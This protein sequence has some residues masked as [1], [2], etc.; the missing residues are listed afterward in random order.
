MHG[1]QCRDVHEE[2]ATYEEYKA[3]PKPWETSGAW[4]TPRGPGDYT[5]RGGQGSGKGDWN[6]KGGKNGK[7]DPGKKPGKTAFANRAN[8]DTFCKLG[9]ECPGKDNGQCNKL[10]V[11]RDEA[12]RHIA[13]DKEKQAK[14]G[15]GMTPRQNA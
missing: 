4:N 13:A 14:T 12:E 10:H 8:W 5:A 15:A 9:L 3:L 2:C 11:A 1:D 7:T 6:P